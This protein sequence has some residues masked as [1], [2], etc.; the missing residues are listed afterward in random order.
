[1]PIPAGAEKIDSI[2]GV[3]L[4]YERLASG[5]PWGD[6]PD[7]EKYGVR[8]MPS[9]KRR[10]TTSFEELFGITGRPKGI[11][12]AGG[13]VEKPGAHGMARAFDLDGIVWENSSWRATEYPSAF[14]CGLL[15]HFMLTF[16]NV[17]GWE[18]NAAH[19]DHFHMDD[20]TQPLFRTNSRSVVTSIQAALKYVWPSAVIEAVGANW[21]DGDW[22]PATASAF[23]KIVPFSGSWPT[24]LSYEEFLR[25]TRDMALRPA[26]TTTIVENAPTVLDLMRLEIADLKKRVARLE[27]R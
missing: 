2:L 10:L 5:D 13:W 25:R 8:V 9:F 21:V 4:Y 16:G 12:T 17:L 22:G 7:S 23:K 24:Q 14:Y 3:P 6:L 26:A 20:L 18:Y 1:M 27:G 19:R 15:C 11:I